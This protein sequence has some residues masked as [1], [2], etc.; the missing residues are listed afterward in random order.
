MTK[1]KAVDQIDPVTGE[2]VRRW[3]TC[4]EAATGVDGVHSTIGRCAALRTG[5]YRG[6]LWRWPG[7]DDELAI[8]PGPVARRMSADTGGWPCAEHKV[9]GF[10]QVCTACKPLLTPEEAFEALRGLRPVH[11]LGL[12]PDSPLNRGERLAD[13]FDRVSK[14]V[15][16][17]LSYECE[18]RARGSSASLWAQGCARAMCETGEKVDLR[19]TY[20]PPTGSSVPQRSVVQCDLMTGVPLETWSSPVAFVESIGKRSGAA[21]P[22]TITANH[23]AKLAAEG[24]PL[25]RRTA[26]GYRWFWED[27]PN[28]PPSEGPAP[29]ADRP[30]TIRQRTGT[31][32]SAE[33][34]LEARRRRAEEGTSIVDLAHEMGVSWSCMRAALRG[35]TWKG[36]QS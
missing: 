26:H 32:L 19:R 29:E 35:W 18:H 3:D 2:L 31:K 34:V 22:I 10:S 7:D 20:A 21:G 24:K 30:L 17:C 33:Q 4:R 25:S 8:Q 23:N 28:P 13:V 14:A 15:Q 36:L 6:F 12:L 11:F 9:T 1:G 27:V 5:P 16:M